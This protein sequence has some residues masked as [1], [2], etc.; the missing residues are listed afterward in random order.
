MKAMYNVWWLWW[1]IDSPSIQLF[2]MQ[3]KQTIATVTD[4]LNGHYTQNQ[5][6]RTSFEYKTLN[7]HINSA[8]V[9]KANS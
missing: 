4:P 8:S 9:F 1:E 2:A 5:T 7:Q 3:L 6:P